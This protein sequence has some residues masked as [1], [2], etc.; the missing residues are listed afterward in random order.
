MTGRTYSDSTPAVNYYYDSQALPS[1]VPVFN[2]GKSAG[3]LVA[4]TYGGASSTTGSYLGAMTN[5][6]APTTALR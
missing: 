4:V 1:G 5:W 2:R 3:M 6:G